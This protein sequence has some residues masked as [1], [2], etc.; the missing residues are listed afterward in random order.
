[1]QVPQ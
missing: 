1:V